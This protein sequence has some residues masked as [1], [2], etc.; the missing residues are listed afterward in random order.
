MNG[1]MFQHHGLFKV[2]PSKTFLIKIPGP[3]FAFL[4]LFFT[5]GAILL[6]LLTLLAGTVNHSPLNNIYFLQ[7]DTSNIP[8]AA[9]QSRWTFW[10]ICRVTNGKSACGAVHPA[11]PLDPTSKSNFHT[12]TGVPHQFYQY[13]PIAPYIRMNLARRIA[14]LLNS[15]NEYYYLTRF[16]FAF[17][18]IGLFFAVCSLFTGF[19]ALCTRIGAYLSGL[20]GFLAMFFQ[21][22]T[23]ALMT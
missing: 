1:S 2:P 17:V 9:A 15:T 18:L 6:I 22:L 13:V 14:N 3:L 8:G 5:A 23:A 20:L 10:N 21:A 12:K 7:A 16:M 4:S 11:F 19:L